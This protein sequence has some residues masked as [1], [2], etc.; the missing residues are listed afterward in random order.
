M[1]QT[2]ER[3]AFQILEA[4]AQ[5][6][7]LRLIMRNASAEAVALRPAFTVR[8]GERGGTAVRRLLRALPDR[9]QMERG[10]LVLSEPAADGAAD[11][12]YG[13]E[14][15]LLAHT[16]EAGRPAAGWARVFGRGVFAEAADEDALAEGAGAVI[17][18]RR[19]PRGAGPRRRRARG[20]C[21]ASRVSPST[22]ASCSCARTSRSSR[23]TSSRSRT[24]RRAS[25]L[26]RFA[27]RACACASRAAPDRAMSRP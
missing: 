20:R 25:M 12:A 27:S 2:G 11:Y 7:G 6:A 23:A 15:A 22:A 18:R 16:I 24:R 21:C 17:A 19:E 4:I 26:R 3:S 14:H 10:L 8:A 5:R 13:A 1:W 9:L